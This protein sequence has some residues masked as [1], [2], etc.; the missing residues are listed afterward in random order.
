MPRGVY[1]TYGCSPAKGDIIQF[2]PAEEIW[3]FAVERK[4]VSDRMKG[5]LKTVVA[6]TGDRVC[7]KESKISINGEFVGEVAVVDS[8]GRPL[9]HAPECI[10][11]QEGQLLP[12]A[13][14]YNKSY[15]GRYFGL[16]P[17]ENIQ[18]CAQPVWIF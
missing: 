18:Y 6:A 14:D 4:Y 8:R 10:I 7:W 12:M 16:I 17:F 1:Y 9:G 3:Q 13:S 2:K 5:L 11:V 15:D